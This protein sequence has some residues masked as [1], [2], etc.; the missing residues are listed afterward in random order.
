[1]VR[2]FDLGHDLWQA[3]HASVTKHWFGT[4]QMA[5]MS[6]SAAG[7]VTVDLVLH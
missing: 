1:M 5:V 3:V 4:S 6:Y 2:T 7:K